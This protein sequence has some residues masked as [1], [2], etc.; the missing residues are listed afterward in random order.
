MK[1][2]FLIVFVFILGTSISAAQDDDCNKTKV[3]VSVD[4]VS[5]TNIYDRLEN[6]FGPRANSEWNGFATNIL[7]QILTEYEPDITFSSLG[8]GSGDFHYHFQANMTLNTV[9]EG[10][11]LH[12][13]YWI[14]ASLVA[15]AN[16]IPLRNWVVDADA[17]RGKDPVLKQAM[18]NL[19]SYFSP[20]DRNIIIYEKDHPSAPRNPEL[21][22]EIEK[23]YISPL[24]KESRKTKVNA[25]VFDCRG[26]LV[27]DKHGHGQP[28]YYQ[29]YIER[30]DLSSGFYEGGYHVGNFMVIITYK[31]CK[32][33]GEYKLEKGVE[34]EKKNIRFNTCQLGGP[35]VEEEKELIIRGLKIEVKPNRKE[36]E[37]DEQTKIVITFNETDP[38][39]SKYPIEGRDIDV[40]ITGLVNGTIKPVNGYTTT[41]EGKVVLNYK[42]GSNDERITVTAS[43]QPEDYPDKAQGR[44][45]VTV[46]PQEFDA[47]INV[48]KTYKKTL[49]TS[50]KDIANNTV[51]NHNIT[52]SIQASATL[53]LT[54]T[55]TMDMPVL[56]Q[57]WQ[58]FKPNSVTVSSIS[59]NSSENKFSS[60]EH[61]QTNVDYDRFVKDQKLDGEE[62][63]KQIPWILVI[64]NE[65]KKPVKLIPAGFGISYEIF[66]SEVITSVKYDG[67]G[68]QERESKTIT[69]TSSES[70]ELGPVAEEVPDPTIKTSD[71]WIQD[72]LKKQG[73]EIPAGVPIPNI[74][75]EETIKKIH[76]DIL[77]K[78]GDGIS[79]FG[80]DGDRRI[81]KELDCGQQEEQL[82]YSW[83]MTRTRKNQ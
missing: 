54:L 3:A 82:H 21:N 79:S 27:C 23:D 36:I 75:N 45:S 81:P 25:K 73:V 59:Y 51:D 76:P 5:N 40:K 37:Q 52:E 44:G 42:A 24:D 33:E 60:S 38:D 78:F 80:G 22:I 61:H 68:G 56:N 47:K 4:I 43:F 9:G 72:Y 1:N 12:T 71:T 15:N 34:A 53:F 7:I 32:N 8:E 14:S 30:L 17:D 55:E 35:L 18:K 28:V 16:C 49:T 46:K 6:D 65:T 10:Q 29:D 64:D 66:E 67:E 39:G 13:V 63:V 2:I 48:R 62:T 77:V 74:S 31:D 69:R 11:N 83:N 26:N 50:C 58:Y 41:S 19:V 20:M 70:F 57:T